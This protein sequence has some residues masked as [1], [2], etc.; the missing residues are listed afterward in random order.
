[1]DWARASG[2]RGDK[3]PVICGSW[4][5]RMHLTYRCVSS[6]CSV[7]FSTIFNLLSHFD[8][9]ISHAP[10]TASSRSAI[11]V[12]NF[13]LEQTDSISEGKASM[14][15]ISQ[16]RKR[17][18][19][20]F[21][22]LFLVIHCRCSAVV[23]HSLQQPNSPPTVRVLWLRLPQPGLLLLRNV[24]E[25]F[26]LPAQRRV[27]GHCQLEASKDADWADCKALTPDEFF[28]IQG[29]HRVRRT[30]SKMSP[31]HKMFLCPFASAACWVEHFLKIQSLS[32]PKLFFFH[33]YKSE[34]M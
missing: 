2:M 7:T 32:L 29:R 31:S 16:P 18:Y 6:I 3:K 33:L 19:K 22:S 5:V 13:H 30:A 14:D 15:L 20:C 1:M 17:W 4:N 25:I 21:D 10:C 27:D 9:F 26:V 34:K 24:A 12:S 11:L 8:F 23:Y 28:Q